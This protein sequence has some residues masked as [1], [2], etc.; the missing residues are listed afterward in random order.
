MDGIDQ[1]CGARCPS[2]TA[3]DQDYCGLQSYYGNCNEDCSDGYETLAMCQAGIPEFF[4]DTE[5]EACTYDRG[6]GCN[7]TIE[8]GSF[9]VTGPGWKKMLS[10]VSIPGN[11]GS[12]YFYDPGSYGPGQLVWK[13]LV[14][15]PGWY[16]V[17]ASFTVK[18]T[19]TRRAQYIVTDLNGNTTIEIDMTRPHE[20][21][22]AIDKGSGN[23]NETCISGLTLLGSFEFGA[24]VGTVM[25]KSGGDSRRVSG[26]GIAVI[27]TNQSLVSRNTSLC[28][29]EVTVAPS[30]TLTMIPTTALSNTLTALL[31]T[32]QSTTVN[33][34]GTSSSTGEGESEDI[35]A[36]V[37]PLVI[38]ILVLLAVL[39][40][41]S[42]RNLQRRDVITTN[43]SNRSF[44][45][46]PPRSTNAPISIHTY[47]EVAN[48]RQDHTYAEISNSYENPSPLIEQQYLELTPLK[49]Q[50]RNNAYDTVAFIETDTTSASKQH[51]YECA[52][53]SSQVGVTTDNEPN[54]SKNG[55]A[56]V[57]STYMYP[58]NY[59]IPYNRDS[60]P[61]NSKS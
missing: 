24:Q 17:S 45:Y 29:L 56:G 54:A 55:T 10:K 42:S 36:V 50:K 8:H 48:P 30:N 9:E 46:E 39:A 18:P 16:N 20:D 34:S 41:K 5:N 3:N 28:R 15:R 1:T 31:P 14:T 25:L 52:N 21:C 7:G 19:R 32:M 57:S 44:E 22:R 47:W 33:Q 35:I 13:F 2:G 43:A 49:S 40:R 53:N 26:D 6:S 11:F 51:Q 23:E 58:G 37:I 27:P 61:Q 4:I 60:M 59:E 38:I 12:S